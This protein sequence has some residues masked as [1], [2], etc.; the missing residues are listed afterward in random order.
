MFK[1][2]DRLKVLSVLNI[3]CERAKKLNFARKN[4]WDRFL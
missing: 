4:A 3:E 1:F 2:Q